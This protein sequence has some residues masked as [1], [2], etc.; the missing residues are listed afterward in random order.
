MPGTITDHRIGQSSIANVAVDVD[1]DVASLTTCEREVALYASDMP[2]RRRSFPNEQVREWIVQGAGRLGI[3]EMRRRALHLQGHGQLQRARLLP[4]L[5]QERH[6]AQF[7][8]RARL[9][10]VRKAVANNVLWDDMTHSAAARNHLGEV[11]GPCP[12]RGTGRIAL[13]E[14]FSMLCPVH[15]ATTI[16]AH[17]RGGEWMPGGVPA[18][19]LASFGLTTSTRPVT[20]SADAAEVWG[21]EA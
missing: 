4:P 2:D 15:S 20:G 11:D 19:V 12:C 7:P 21:V 16:Q 18:E 1:V 8:K 14:A 10:A 3:E 13:A 5:V 17:Q 9:D 6:Q